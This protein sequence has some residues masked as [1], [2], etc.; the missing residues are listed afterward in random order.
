MIF[1]LTMNPTSGYALNV[2]SNHVTKAD[3]AP[4]SFSGIF[5]PV[6]YG[7]SARNSLRVITPR[8]FGSVLRLP[9][10][11]GLLKSSLVGVLKRFTKGALIMNAISATAA[12]TAEKSVKTYS[13]MTAAELFREQKRL[14]RIAKNEP[15]DDLSDKICSLGCDLYD[16]IAATP[17]TTK[18]DVRAKV[19]FMLDFYVSYMGNEIMPVDRSFFAAVKTTLQFLKGV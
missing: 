15:N 8:F 6:I 3:T 12:L 2:A 1:S 14:F 7:G 10:P 19:L 18:E 16:L 17:A 11:I 9:P 4:E 5:M 13:E